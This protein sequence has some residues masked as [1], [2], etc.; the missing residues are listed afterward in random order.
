MAF[1]DSHYIL[2]ISTLTGLLLALTIQVP[3][4][5]GVFS[6]A[7]VGAYG[8]GAYTAGI[9]TLRWE[10][11]SFLAMVLAGALGAT[12]CVLLGLIVLRLDGIYLA[13]A[14]VSFVLIVTVVATNGGTL[15]GGA[16]GL[17]GVIGSFATWQV[18]TMVAAA[19]LV[20]AV[21][22]HGRLGRRVDVVREDPELAASLGISVRGYRLAA[23]G[24]SGALGGVAGAVTT[25]LLT[26]V[27]PPDI[28]FSLVVLGLTMIIV[29]GARSW[30]G[31]LIGAII[32][33]WLPELLT[34]IGEYQELVYGV[35]VALAAVL[36]PKGLYGIGRSVALRVRAARRPTIQPPGNAVTE[37]S[38]DDATRPA[39]VPAGTGGHRHE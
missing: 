20:V 5:F 37:S 16:T 7:G 1:F 29:G 13:M 25:L 38:T 9:A 32:F 11:D 28:G 24:L 36:M 14:S 23:C 22:E 34:G 17:Y 27:S 31:A 35:I 2:I 15:T 10:L 21:T 18:V 30:W 33:T 12:V 6:L 39:A 8:I 3:L 26:T 4:R 19:V